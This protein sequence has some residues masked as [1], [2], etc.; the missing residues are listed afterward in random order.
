M[1]N[2]SILRKKIPLT[3]VMFKAFTETHGVLLREEYH[4]RERKAASHKF[5]PTLP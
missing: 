3:K 1:K 5:S 2:V 4:F